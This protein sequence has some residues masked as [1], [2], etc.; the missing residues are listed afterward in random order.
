MEFY[1][2]PL[3][4]MKRIERLASLLANKLSWL[5]VFIVKLLIIH[6]FFFLQ[7]VGFYRF[8]DFNKK[9]PLCIQM[10]KSL[11]VQTLFGFCATW[12]R[13]YFPNLS[14]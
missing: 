14:S 9:K 12:F 6:A 5:T 10:V 2:S 11:S 1:G 3:H 4:S 7:P 13:T 8:C